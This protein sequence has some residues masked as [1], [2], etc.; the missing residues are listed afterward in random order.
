M[1]L[2]TF[3]TH[4]YTEHWAPQV[5]DPAMY[6]GYPEVWGLCQVQQA[7]L[8]V[9]HSRGT[10]PPPEGPGGAPVQRQS[11]SHAASAVGSTQW[12]IHQIPE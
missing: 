8:P 10:I 11:V 4:L 3:K 1:I 9:P 5:V 2:Y 7:N 6:S 12:R